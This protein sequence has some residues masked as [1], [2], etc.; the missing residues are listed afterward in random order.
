M[1]RAA[2]RWTPTY[3]PRDARYLPTPT[4]P[5]ASRGTHTYLPTRAGVGF[6]PLHVSGGASP[7]RRARAAPQRP[8]VTSP[9]FRG[10]A[11]SPAWLT[12]P[13]LVTGALSKEAEAL[14]ACGPASLRA[15][16]WARRAPHGGRRA[17]QRRAGVGARRAGRRAEPAAG[18]GAFCSLFHARAAAALGG[19]APGA[20]PRRARQHG[21]RHAGAHALPP[22]CIDAQAERSAAAIRELGRDARELRRRAQELS[23]PATFV[24]SAKLARQAAAK[25]K[26]R[27][28]RRRVSAPL[29]P[30]ALCR[31]PPAC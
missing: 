11:P 1:S 26:A 27:T 9:A 25:E 5:P 23:A 22:S 20:P 8:F 21:A 12:F 10:R 6:P 19:A 15:R 7:S 2:L 30:A 16:S 13:L 4:Y 24:E 14:A 28:P 17:A 31:S 29:V 3:P 18:A